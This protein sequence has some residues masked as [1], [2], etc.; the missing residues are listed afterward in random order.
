MTAT[1]FG[2]AYRYLG[3]PGTI[4]SIAAMQSL[5]LDVTVDAQSNGPAGIGFLVLVEDR[6]GTV[7]TYSRFGIREGTHQIKWS[8]A[9]PAS[10]STPGSTPG[11]DFSDIKSINIHIDP[12]GPNSYT[13][14]FNDLKAMADASAPAG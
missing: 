11:L 6:D 10:T 3:G 9:S 14:R 1:N 12:G 13:V 4:P 5:V 8:L 7:N 2:G